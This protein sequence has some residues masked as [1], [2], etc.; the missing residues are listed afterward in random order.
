MQSTET[1]KTSVL[2]LYTSDMKCAEARGV[3]LF[4]E[5][6]DFVIEKWQV[7]AHHCSPHGKLYVHVDM[8]ETSQVN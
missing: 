4:S 5:L 1:L 6:G 3:Q 8:T 7:T 2:L